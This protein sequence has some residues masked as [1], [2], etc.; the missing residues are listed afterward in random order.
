VIETLS[1]QFVPVQVHIKE[2]KE[3]FRRFNVLWTPTQILLDADGVEWHR[4]EGFLPVN[5]FL[6]QLD[7]G[8]GKH[9]FHHEDYGKA[10]SV[11]RGVCEAFRD[12]GAGPEACYWAGVA[13][14]KD[15]KDAGHLARTAKLLSEKFPEN[16][17]ARKAS[18]W[19]PA[20]ERANRN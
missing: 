10:E 3:V 14:Y 11:F 7:L 6:A 20:A 4:I 19:Q 8:L 2:Q 5:D 13:A 12:S 1:S 9:H 17:W 15:S 16:E 18:V